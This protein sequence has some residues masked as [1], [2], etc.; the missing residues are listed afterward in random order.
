MLAIE[1]ATLVQEEQPAKAV[2][3]EIT[4]TK[5]APQIAAAKVTVAAPVTAPIAKAVVASSPPR[6]TNVMVRDSKS[7]D[8]KVSKSPSKASKSPSKSPAKVEKDS[9]A[10]KTEDAFKAIKDASDAAAKE[11]E[12]VTVTVAKEKPAEKSGDGEKKG[13][14]R[15][16]SRKSKAAK[17]EKA[18]GRK[19]RSRK[20]KRCGKKCKA[21]KCKKDKVQTI[22]LEAPQP[23]QP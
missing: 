2:K 9:N 5:A 12:S 17:R 10:A 19:L 6:S 18:R 15:M 20:N 14:P 1:T 4:Q 13:G 22:T 23:A 3:A 8:A 7:P 11:K 16:V 21:K